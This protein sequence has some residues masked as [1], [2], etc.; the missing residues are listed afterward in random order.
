[1]TIETLNER[2]TCL[3][4]SNTKINL[5]RLERIRR[6]VMHNLR[7]ILEISIVRNE[8]I[9]DTSTSFITRILECS[10]QCVTT[11][12]LDINF[13]LRLRYGCALNRTGDNPTKQRKIILR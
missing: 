7:F 3:I 1:M 11:Q 2:N 4:T 12:H 9:D 10:G 8:S 6:K 13:S 5:Q